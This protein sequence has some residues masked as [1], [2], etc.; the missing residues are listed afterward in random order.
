MPKPKG[1]KV[2][3]KSKRVKGKAVGVFVNG[4]LDGQALSVKAADRTV[5][6][7]HKEGG[8]IERH[9]NKTDAVKRITRR[10]PKITPTVSR[11][12]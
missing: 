4:E 12:L 11:R 2:E 8:T 6:L 7:T 1:P 10:F 5:Y 9:T 3:V